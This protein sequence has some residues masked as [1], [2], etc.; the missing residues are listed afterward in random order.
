M[1]FPTKAKPVYRI[2]I[3]KP[4]T[5][6]K[7]PLGIPPRCLQ[8]LFKLALEPEWETKFEDN[9]YGF[10]PGKNCHD[11]FCAIRN[12]VIKK[13][14]YVID[15][16][17]SKCFDRINHEALLDKIGMKGA[18]RRQIKYWLKSGVFDFS[19]LRRFRRI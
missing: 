2:W 19:P 15:A 7:R 1:K 4:G 3:P 9:S 17:I 8:A 13:A 18:Y 12:S 5:T 10:R 14:K 11:A 16:D 6:E